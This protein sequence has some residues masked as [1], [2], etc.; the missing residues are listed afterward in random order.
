M[1]TF[2]Y[3]YLGNFPANHVKSGKSGKSP[4]CVEVKI[5]QRL[6]CQGLHVTQPMA[7][8]NGI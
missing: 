3:D 1:Y 8:A 6:S 5:P 4:K 7:M 2:N